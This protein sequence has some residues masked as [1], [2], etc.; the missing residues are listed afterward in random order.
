MGKAA[1]SA[2]FV[3]PETLITWQRK[4]FRDHWANMS[5][6]GKPGRSLI[7]EEIRG[8]IRKVSGANPLWSRRALTRRLA[9]SLLTSA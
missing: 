4:R 6:A 5:I 8:I 9:I 7:N 3:Q 2:V 1:A